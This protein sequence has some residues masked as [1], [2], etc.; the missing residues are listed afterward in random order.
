MFLGDRDGYLRLL[1]IDDG[2]NTDD[3][4]VTRNSLSEALDTTGFALDRYHVPPES[5]LPGG[6]HTHLDQ[7]EV[8][9]VLQGRLTFKTLSETVTVDA[10][11][12]VRFA[13]G[14]YQ[15]GANDSETVAVV[16]AIGAP[17]GSEAVRVPCSCPDC[18]EER[19]EPR[20]C[21]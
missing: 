18:G 3:S 19:S 20:W 21:E 4:G 6:L 12:A 1:S 7:E 17:E 8:F 10:G 15:T 5:G 16:V 13:R 2:D 9:V 11:E 14:E